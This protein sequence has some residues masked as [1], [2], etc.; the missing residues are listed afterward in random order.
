[1]GSLAL[2]GS[3]SKGKTTLD[4]KSLEKAIGSHSIVFFKK[5]CEFKDNKE[6][7]DVESHDHLNPDGTWQFTDSFFIIIFVFP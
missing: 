3:Q 7:G 4:T 1:M 6:K 2:R 5:S